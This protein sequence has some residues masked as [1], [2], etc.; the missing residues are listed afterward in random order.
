[1]RGPVIRQ[2]AG[3]PPNRWRAA[4]QVFDLTGA[5]AAG[6]D[7][8]AG[9]VLVGALSEQPERVAAAAVGIALLAAATS[10]MRRHFALLPVRPLV[11]ELSGPKPPSW[12][13]PT[14]LVLLLVGLALG[15]LTGTKTW[16]L[17]ALVGLIRALV[18]ISPQRGGVASAV[19]G[20]L[21]RAGGLAAGLALDWRLM[22]ERLEVLGIMAIFFLALGALQLHRQPEWRQGTPLLALLHVV[23]ATVLTLYP[24][25]LR[26]ETGLDF[27]FLLA[28]YLV[29]VFPPLTQ[30]A[31]QPTLTRTRAA[32]L[33]VEAGVFLLE[34]TLV[35][36]YVSLAAG[37]MM[38]T[39]FVVVGALRG[40]QDPEVG[41][42]APVGRA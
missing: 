18:A 37:L 19:T 22:F 13:W 30:A 39:A 15:G 12:W 33:R 4:A 1:M 20:A 8:I 31:M 7:V 32:W 42:E 9:G 2:G 38:A 21:A 28:A 29:L 10:G 34:A 11:T 41:Q 36:G 23:G 6:A 16:A 27:W 17:L 5:V 40:W 25:S 3:A 24:V 14:S 35:A 26:F